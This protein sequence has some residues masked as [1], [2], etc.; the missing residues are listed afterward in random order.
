LKTSTV[1]EP[2]GTCAPIPQRARVTLVAT[3]RWNTNRRLKRR[4]SDGIPLGKQWKQYPLLGA[5]EAKIPVDHIA[6][7]QA[8][9]TLTLGLR[10]ARR[11]RLATTYFEQQSKFDPL[12]KL[13]N[14]GFFNDM[15]T[16]ALERARHSGAKLAV[17]F[18]EFDYFKP[19]NDTYGHHAGD[20]VLYETGVR[21]RECLREADLVTRH[22][23]AIP[24]A[25]G[26]PRLRNLAG[27]HAAAHLSNAAACRLNP[28]GNSWV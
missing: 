25:T 18:I 1:F 13:G 20:R 23:G 12:T 8:K 15:G 21:L 10:D 19:I 22:G 28:R 26:A 11:E 7:D 16:A 2:C 9:A 4:I 6:A 24:G 5:L 3:T 14:R 27:G 17:L